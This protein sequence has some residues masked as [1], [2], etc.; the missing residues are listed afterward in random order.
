MKKA[1][2]K[3]E[4]EYRCFPC[5]E[6]DDKAR[7]YTRSYNLVLHMMNTHRKFSID[8]KHNA[9]YA[10]DGSDVRDATREEIEKY[11]L[12][13]LHKPKKLDAD[14]AGGKSGSST[15]VVRAGKEDKDSPQ[16]RDE[17]TRG[18]NSSRDRKRDRGSRNR[19]AEMKDNRTSSRDAKKKKDTSNAERPK[20][21]AKKD[22]RAKE[23]D[24]SSGERR[25]TDARKD[26]RA[27]EKDTRFT[28]RRKTDVKMEEGRKGKGRRPQ[29]IAGRKIWV[30]RHRRKIGGCTNIR[31]RSEAK[32][33]DSTN[34]AKRSA[35]CVTW[36]KSNVVWRGVGRQK[37]WNVLVRRKKEWRSRSLLFVLRPGTNHLSKWTPATTKE[38]GQLENGACQ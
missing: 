33:P 14:A 1:A 8:A 9:Y 36:R 2:K 16:K 11:H 29:N 13:A 18:R 37:N 21:D 25:K 6:Q 24:T 12:T 10:A 31:K 19:E 15:S 28:E 27:K 30:R 23:K 5:Q 4:W 7:K 22:E 3:P 32:I 35:T 38:T 34:W 26:E 20:T 17:K